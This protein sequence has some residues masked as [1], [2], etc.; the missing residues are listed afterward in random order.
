MQT[1]P[2]SFI[3]VL[4]AD[5][6]E[7]I[8]VFL[9]VPFH[10]FLLLRVADPAE[11]KTVPQTPSEQGQQPWESLTVSPLFSTLQH[12]AVERTRD[13]SDQENR[14]KQES[15]VLMLVLHQ[16]GLKIDTRAIKKWWMG[17]GSG[18]CCNQKDET[19][20]SSFPPRGAFGLVY[21]TTNTKHSLHTE[22]PCSCP[23]LTTSLTDVLLKC[24]TFDSSWPA[25]IR[26]CVCVWMCS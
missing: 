7:L 15:E 26:V 3:T 19:C 12:P 13:D 8:F 22:L 20:I 11:E 2:P 6:T 1:C 5:D 18:R 24:E 16:W 9:S 23:A 4:L 21:D 25:L 14:W 10:L 17:L